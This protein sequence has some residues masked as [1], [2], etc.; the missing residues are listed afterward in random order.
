[1]A[2]NQKNFIPQTGSSFS[3]QYNGTQTSLA[4]PLKIWQAGSEGGKFYGAKIKSNGTSGAPS[5]QTIFWSPDGVSFVSIGTFASVPSS[6]TIKK[7]FNDFWDT[8]YVNDADGNKYI[9]LESGAGFFIDVSDN[10]E[11]VNIE[12]YGENY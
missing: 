9:N 4:A 6:T 7:I 11:T 10:T 8:A 12:S 1:M 5:T 2:K 3:V